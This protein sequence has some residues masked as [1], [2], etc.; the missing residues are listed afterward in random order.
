MQ[1]GCNPAA[2]GRK[3]GPVREVTDVVV[4]GGGGAGMAAAS[5]AARVGRKV[6]LLEKEAALGG[7]TAWSVGSISAT[8]TPHQLR[9]AIVDS[10][11]EHFDDLEKLA[12]AYA[13]RDNREL[14]RILVDH[15]SEMFEWLRS[16]GL[17]FVGP[18]PEPPH[19]YPRMHNVLPNSRAFPACLGRHCRK[20]GVD[21]RLRT[22]ATSLIR[23]GQRVVGVKIRGPR[24]SAGEIV[25]R[26]GVVL[27]SGDYSASAA[28][29]QKF[30]GE[31]AARLD[32]V[33]PAA[34]GDGFPLALDVG[35][36]VINGDIVRGPIMRFVP[37]TKR[38]LLQW[39]PPHPWLTNLM[40]LT[41][42]LL[43]SSLLR[44]FIMSF[45]TT[46]LGPS[47]ELFKRGAI[48]VNKAGQRFVDELKEPAAS[49]P[50][51]PDKIAYIV[52]DERLARQFSAWPYFVSTAP[53][54]AYAYIEDYRRNRSDIYHRADTIE[55]LAFS[56]GVPA[57]ALKATIEQNPTWSETKPAAPLQPPFYALGPVKSYVVFTDGG[58]KVTSRL[59]VVHTSGAV[60]PGLYAA[61]STGQGGVLLEGHGHH[62]GWAF[63][64]G[65]IAGRNAAYQASGTRLSEP[66]AG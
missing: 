35:A 50:L 61:G 58:L 66:A 46:A 22:K 19:R 24:D 14:R 4:V 51:Q 41:F 42:D 59:E 36:I 10:P 27:A 60:I 28:L 15:T 55:G 18:S 8:C 2:A 53:G 3:A 23:D 57:G 25:V 65:R 29:K 47:G 9:R 44:P 13:D 26:G 52:L 16:T 45:L 7:S 37:P 21:I 48:L 34:T 39:L 62:L 5:E 11:D 31:A 40:R 12:G 54:V 20:L 30:A 38:N 43:P 32:P 64:S 1:P 6:I 49:V 56:L 17:V 33:N 63:I